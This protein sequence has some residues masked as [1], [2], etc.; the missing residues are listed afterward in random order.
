MDNKDYL[1]SLSND[2]IIG[3]ENF[4]TS[5]LPFVASSNDRLLSNARSNRN[6]MKAFFNEDVDDFSLVEEE[7]RG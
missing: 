4:K 5:D 6:L 7:T 3:E 2:M 1:K